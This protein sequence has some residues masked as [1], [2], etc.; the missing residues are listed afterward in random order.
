MFVI[1]KTF[2]FEAAHRL[3]LVPAGHKCRRL[4][5]HNYVVTVE[6]AAPDLNAAAFVVDYGDLGPLKEHLARTYDHR[7]LNDV[8]VIETTAE[9]LAWVL[10]QWCA[11]HWPQTTAVRVSET[12]NT[13]AEYRP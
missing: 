13:T 11:R 6:L 7:L 2:E 10:Y 9:N 12:R 5:G 3:T 1:T 4:H 8:M